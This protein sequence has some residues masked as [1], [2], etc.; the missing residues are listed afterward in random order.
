MKNYLNSILLA[1]FIVIFPGI[2]HADDTASGNEVSYIKR[3]EAEGMRTPP[4][5]SYV[6]TAEA[7]KTIY[8]SGMTPTLD[9]KTVRKMDFES[10]VR[11]VY[12]KIGRA[13]K[14]A[15]V[16][17]RHVVRQRVHIVDITPDHAPVMRKV[18]QEFYQ[19]PGPA[20]TAVGT[21]GLFFP[22]LLVEVDVTAVINE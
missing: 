1:A 8:I 22:D 10:Q 9:G 3:I 7:G 21:S 20:S 17:P 15:G 11:N 2:S 14:A 4:H 13:L 12:E 5:F 18:M 16:S 6:V 19:G